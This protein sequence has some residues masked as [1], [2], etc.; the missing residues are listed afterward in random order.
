MGCS[1]Y[2]KGAVWALV[3]GAVLAGMIVFTWFIFTQ[4]PGASGIMFVWL[5]L[6]AVVALIFLYLLFCGWWS[7]N[8]RDPM[9]E[10]FCAQNQYT[11]QSAPRAT[12]QGVGIPD[13][14]NDL[15]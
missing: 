13:S 12:F 2:W 9:D 3:E 10:P 6:M 14:N 15:V 7:C 5:P 1:L 8:G 11:P 4:H